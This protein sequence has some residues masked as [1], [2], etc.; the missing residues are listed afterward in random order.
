MRNRLQKCVGRFQE[1]D[2]A[3][4]FAKRFSL[5]REQLLAKEGAVLEN[6]VILDEVQKVCQILDEV[7][8][9]IEKRGLRFILCGSSARKPL[10]QFYW[11]SPY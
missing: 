2:Q 9:L 7:H 4:E 3:L 10:Q 1:G 6:P 8:W 5:L 11:P